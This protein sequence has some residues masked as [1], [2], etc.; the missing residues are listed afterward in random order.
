MYIVQNVLQ[1]HII[2]HEGLTPD[3]GN[4]LGGNYLRYPWS[5]PWCP[6]KCSNELNNF[7]TWA[8]FLS[9]LKCT[10]YTGKTP[11]CHCHFKNECI[12]PVV[13][14]T[15]DLQTPFLWH[16]QLQCGCFIKRGKEMLACN[17]F[18]LNF[19][20]FDLCNLSDRLWS[21]ACLTLPSQHLNH[22]GTNSISP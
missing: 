21:Y 8:S 2:V 20:S 5:L 16:V 22:S 6:L 18:R 19:P 10:L 11:S 14:F 13:C 3:G 4:G 15:K 7:L 1:E 9:D 12:M 17:L